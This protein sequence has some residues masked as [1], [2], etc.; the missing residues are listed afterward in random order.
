[1]K[2]IIYT[3]QDGSLCIVLPVINTFPQPENI[4]EDQAVQ[5]ALA[6]LPANAINPQVVD[7]AVLPS[8]RSK[9][10]AWRQNGTAVVIDPVAAAEIDTKVNRVSALNAEAT[11]DV[12]ID[13]L[14]SAT[15]DQIKT[16]VQNNITD[17]ASV[18]QFIGRLACAVAYAL[19]GGGAK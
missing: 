19:N 1:M 2:R 10:A 11:A 17:L 5:R 12:F 9:R 18:R 4:T 7:E 3:R 13:N 14:R 15:P 8:D 6:K 16:Y